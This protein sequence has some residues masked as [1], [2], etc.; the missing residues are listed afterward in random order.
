M[1]SLSF[2]NVLSIILLSTKVLGVLSEK[3]HMPQVVGALLAGL[4]LGPSF[5]GVLNEN[6]FI[7]Q[8]A[9]IGVIILMFLAGLDTNLEELKKNGLASVIIAVLGVTFSL[10]M[11]T[12]VYW[13]FFGVDTSNKLEVLKAVFTGV[14]LISTSVSITVETLSEMGK[15]KGR[16][17]TT[18]LG[19]AIIDD[20]LGIIIL[21]IIT[22][23]NDSTVKTISVLFNIVKF[24]LFIIVLAFVINHLKKYFD[25][26]EPGRRVSVYSL[27][28]C[29]TISYISERFFGI[30]D[31]IGA[32]F[33]GVLLCNLGFKTYVEK[34][35]TVLSYLLFSP[36]FFASI[37]L[38]TSLE[39]IT[40]HIVIFAIVLTIIAILTKI[41]GCYTGAK[42][43]KFDNISALAIGIGMVSRG[44]VNLIIAEKGHNVGLL[45]S[46]LFPAVVIVVIVTTLVTPIILKVLLSKYEI[47]D[48][49]TSSTIKR[50]NH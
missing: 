48:E 26:K 43:S 31:V 21:T 30:T 8:S 46:A 42:I 25:A 38:K 7:S 6:E 50:A 24:A 16:M 37:G 22:S 27:V 35:I 14:V 28:F 20:I 41:A 36:M 39:G 5:L 23:L 1:E 17:G 11:G 9:E 29:F 34:K 19:A 15:L 40:L 33:T 45:D 2:L 3:V 12:L 44:E 32:Y 13:V 47:K 49:K 4:F 18:I 10:I